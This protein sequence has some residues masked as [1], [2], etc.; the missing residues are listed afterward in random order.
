MTPEQFSAVQTLAKKSA[1][2]L[3]PGFTVEQARA[4]AASQAGK[5]T[6]EAINKYRRENPG[7]SH[8]QAFAA[9]VSA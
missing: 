5:V 4:G 8:E 1:P 7:A 3:P 2:N 9:L 6:P